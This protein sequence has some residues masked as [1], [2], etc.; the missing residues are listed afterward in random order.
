MNSNLQ[1]ALINASE[2][3][4]E[5]YKIEPHCT[6]MHIMEKEFSIKFHHSS[7]S[8]FLL[9]DQVEFD[10]ENSATFFILKWA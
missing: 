9:L 10:I 8:H 1:Q 3:I 5:K 2:F 6:T 4:R 7:E